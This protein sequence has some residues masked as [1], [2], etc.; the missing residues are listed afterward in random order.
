MQVQQLQLQQEQLKATSVLRP[1]PSIYT[2][3]NMATPYQQPAGSA[4]ALQPQFQHQYTPRRP[5][6]YP[7]EE[8][9]YSRRTEY[10]QRTK[11]NTRPGTPSNLMRRR[12]H[13]E[14]LHAKLPEDTFS[15][16]EEIDQIIR[17]DNLTET[18]LQQLPVKMPRF[19]I[20][21]YFSQPNCFRNLPTVTNS[22]SKYMVAHMRQI[23]ETRVKEA[24]TE[25]EWIDVLGRH[26]QEDPL[27]EYFNHK[28][29]TCLLYTS[30]SPRD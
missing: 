23:L 10:H 6:A 13:G 15:E 1:N 26:L 30:P 11:S 7:E 2:Q 27:N 21:D 18:E 28:A 25:T 9:R 16:D 5:S 29:G 20:G 19:G 17:T 22:N 3:D 4:P 8:S 14:H 12:S 24:L